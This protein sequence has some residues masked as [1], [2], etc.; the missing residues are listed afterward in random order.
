VIFIENHLPTFEEI[1]SM[2]FSSKSTSFLRACLVLL[3]NLAAAATTTNALAGGIFNPSTSSISLPAQITVPENATNGSVLWKSATTTLNL[4]AVNAAFE[5]NITIAQL[6]AN[7]RS[8]VK[9]TGYSDIYSTNIP[10]L[11]IRWWATWR[12]PNFPSGKTMP[13][14]VPAENNAGAL[15]WTL[16][17]GT[18]TQDVWVELVKIGNISNG[19]LSPSAINAY[20]QFQCAP[21]CTAA[22]ISVAGSTTVVVG[23]SC[24][25]AN[26]AISVPMGAVP[27]L[28]FTGLR[29]TSVPQRFDITLDCK[30]GAPNSKLHPH[31]TL[32]DANDIGNRST[33]LSL[34]KATAGGKPV[35]TGIGIQI[36]K[37]GVP[38]AYGPDSSAP[39]NTNQWSAGTIAQGVSQFKISLTASYV[40]TA[41]AVTLGQA[42]GRATFTLNYQ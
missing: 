33:I 34:N 20:L 7:I 12:G 14:T 19:M 6:H 38:L 3:I 41:A 22:T 9:A 13:I 16:L 30:G 4:S 17:T 39:G 18:Y 26:S 35:A 23:P 29:S 42:N 27:I 15:G 21:S 36:L 31:V 1:R 28:R 11:G 10:G 40:Q 25:V 37:D 2:Y 24:T 8:G 5:G 32:T